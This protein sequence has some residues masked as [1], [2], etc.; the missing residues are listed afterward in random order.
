MPI[1]GSNE[2]FYDTVAHSGWFAAVL[3]AT[4]TAILRLLIGRY[5]EYLKESREDRKRIRETLEN[6][7]QRLFHLEERNRLEDRARK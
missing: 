4:W 6:I 5:G 2:T 1:E 7:D 3:L